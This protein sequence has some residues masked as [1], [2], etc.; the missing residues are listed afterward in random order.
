MILNDWMQE[1]GIASCIISDNNNNIK[2]EGFGMAQCHPDDEPFKSETIGSFIAES[3]A[4]IDI[5]RKIRDYDLKPGLT[6]LQHLQSTMVKSNHYNPE[7]YESK[8]LKKE[9]QNQK[10]EID[11]I[12]EI[13]REEKHNLNFYLTQR[14][15]FEKDKNN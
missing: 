11:Y 8:R 13:L 9:I 4:R 3:R 2:I 14:C 5:L 12:N 10:D 15:D 7:S 6:A 1:T